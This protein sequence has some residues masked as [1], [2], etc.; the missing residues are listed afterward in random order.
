MNPT[1][2]TS[3]QLGED[4][5]PQSVAAR[6][7]I[8]TRQ[9]Q[10]GS[11]DFVCLCA[12]RY[13]HHGLPRSHTWTRTLTTPLHAT[14]LHSHVLSAHTPVPHSHLCF[15]YKQPIPGALLGFALAAAK[16]SATLHIHS[17]HSINT[18][19][20]PTP[21]HLGQVCKRDL[22]VPPSFPHQRVFVCGACI[23]TAQVGVSLVSLLNPL[24]KLSR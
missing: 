17:T 10:C 16:D 15:G 6:L 21:T 22:V 11:A 8:G 20:H 5:L 7:M 9:R 14:T 19:T 18:R 1:I 12:H 13:L 3:R 23:G 2:T 24:F 4:S